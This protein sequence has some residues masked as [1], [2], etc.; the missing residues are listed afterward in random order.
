MAMRSLHTATR[1]EAPC[2]PKLEKSLHAETKTPDSQYVYIILYLK[3]S[4][5][6]TLFPNNSRSGVLLVT[7]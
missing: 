5:V 3:K 7:T 6:K 4:G 2:S 1:E